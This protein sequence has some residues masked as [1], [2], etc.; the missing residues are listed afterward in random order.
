MGAL[1]GTVHDVLVDQFEVEGIDQRVAHALVLE[2]LAP[3][4]HEPALRAGRRLVRNNVALDAAVLEGREVVA[5]R[6]GA[7]GVFLAEQ[8]I[9]RGEADEGYFAVAII[10]VTD[11]IEVVEA[12]HH[13]KVRAPPILD[14]IEFDEVPDLDPSD[15]VRPAAERR[16]QSRL[17]EFVFGIERT[18]ENRQGGDEQRHVAA[19]LGAEL[20]HQYAVVDRFRAG[21]IA[22]QLGDDR[23]ASF[24]QRRQRPHNILRGD[25]RSVVEF[26]ALA[27]RKPIGQTVIGDADAFCRQPIHRVRFVGRARHQAGENVIHAERAIALENVG[28]ER[29]ESQ[30]RAVIAA[31]AD[32]FGIH[33]ALGCARIDVGEIRKVGRILQIAEG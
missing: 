29:I 10:F 21:K 12:L 27:H 16:R 25:R 17:V 15:L 31:A 22:Q 13:R 30:E 20:C 4:V 23:V 8:I 5:R 32:G 9:F 3:H 28:I 2:F 33:A 1:V 18:G 6:P 26:R 24:L 14:A 11:G 7:R 19:A